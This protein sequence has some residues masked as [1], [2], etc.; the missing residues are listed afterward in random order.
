MPNLEHA[1]RDYD[2]VMLAVIAARWDIDLE[3]H[4]V[5]DIR[6]ALLQVMLDPNAAAAVWDRLDDE[7]RG[8]MQILLG[9]RGTMAAPKFY[10]LYGEIR[11]MG[12]GRLEREKLY[13]D[14]A[15]VAE[16]LYYRG[17]IARGFDEA[18]A[19][20]Q[21]VIYVPSDLARVLPAH[22]TGF[23]LS[24][25]DED[26][27]PPDEDDEP[28]PEGW[29]SPADQPEEIWAADT[30]L[31]D[32]LATVLAYL[33][34]AAVEARPDGQLPPSHLD[35]LRHFLLK[36]EDD[37]LAFLLGLARAL[38]L[39]AP[40]DGLLKP[41]SHNARRWLEAPRSEQV[42]LLAA[43]WR[44]TTDF[45]ELFHTPGLV[46]ET[47]GNDPRL[48]RAMILNYLADLPPDSW[49]IVTGVVGEIREI[50]ADFQRPG[51]DYES[52]YIRR[53]E[54]GDYLLGFE[55]WDGVEGAQLRYILTGPLHWLGLADLGRYAGGLLGRLNAY[56]RALAAGK[57]WPARPDEAEALRLQDNGTAEVSRRFSRYDRFQLARFSEWLSGA[58]EGY[59]YRFSPR[60]L[61]RASAQGIKEPHIRAFL[62]RTTGSDKLPEGVE[63]MLARWGQTAEADATIEHLTVLRTRSAQALDAV[64]NEPAVRRY[65]GARLGPEA[66][67]VRPGQGPALQDALA[68]HGLLA[69]LVDSGADAPG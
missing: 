9:A 43:G 64:L 16:A 34:V 22:R 42:R 37:R 24:Q 58:A 51:G 47:A 59:R 35:T 53:A 57:G 20:P 38:G 15:S 45:N 33:Q 49:W 3:S 13:L 36:P 60:G 26:D 44:E 6:G 10:R 18:A 2:P 39:L 14:P 4:S 40:R 63:A 5:T 7:Q 25:A 67:I 48:G 66:V 30:T 55:S 29:S 23:D 31:V 56:G 62:T 27:L 17:L 61:R 8:A 52:W 28:L 65:L 12:P 46:V 69:D 32:D 19:G 1:L 54:G 11:E 50:D 41:V 68:E 21:A